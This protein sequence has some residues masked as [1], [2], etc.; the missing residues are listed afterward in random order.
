MTLNV[1]ADIR[2][3]VASA[4]T[5]PARPPLWRVLVSAFRG[6]RRFVPAIVNLLARPMDLT[7]DWM[8]YIRAINHAMSLQHVIALFDY[9]KAFCNGTGLGDD[10]DRRK[11]W[12]QDDGRIAEDIQ[13]DKVRTCILNTH[14]GVEVGTVLRLET[15]DGNQPPPMKA[16]RKHP[17]RVEDIRVDDYLYTPQSHRWLFFAAN[18]INT[19][20]VV[21]PFAHGGFYPWFGER[22]ATWLPLVSR[23]PVSIALEY[24]RRLA[25]GAA[26][27]SPYS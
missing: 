12:L 25:D 8:F 27:P 20:D 16:G 23:F 11:N 2:F 22:P 5:E 14:T 13:F 24:V 6:E 26:I 10:G 21:T 1:T 4:V 18:N 15:L 19:K 17:L 9:Q 3:G 7:R